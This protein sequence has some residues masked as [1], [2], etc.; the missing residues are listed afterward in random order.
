MGELQRAV[1]TQQFIQLREGDRFF[2]L[3]SPDLST[4]RTVFG[5]D[6]RRRLGDIIAQDG[7]ID[8]ADLAQNVFFAPT[9]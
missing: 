5:I 2:Y 6:F 8:R 4:I 9:A 3:N 7:G 1:W